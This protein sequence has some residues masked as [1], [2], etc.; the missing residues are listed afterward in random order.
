M[1]TIGYL[2]AAV[3]MISVLSFVLIFLYCSLNKKTSV[4]DNNLAYFDKIGRLVINSNWLFF[5]DSLTIKDAEKIKL[6][7]NEYSIFILISSDIQSGLL[8][9]STN[10]NP[11]SIKKIL[12]NGTCKNSVV[13]VDSGKLYVIAEDLVFTKLPNFVPIRYIDNEIIK[14]DEDGYVY[15]YLAVQPIYGDGDY[16]MR[17]YDFSNDSLIALEIIPDSFEKLLIRT[18]KENYV[19]I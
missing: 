9:F 6:Q 18:W 1:I 8:L 16:G 5:N 19:P 10:N 17:Y 2:C 13:L 11:D 12:A 14:F 4:D 3:A 7:I 15:S